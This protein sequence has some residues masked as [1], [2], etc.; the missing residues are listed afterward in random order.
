MR[1]NVSAVSDTKEVDVPASFEI[2]TK[3]NPD[4]EASWR[5][6]FYLCLAVR[7]VNSLLV[8][9]YFN[10]DEHWQ[11]LEVA[12]RLVFGYRILVDLIWPFFF[13]FF[14]SIF[15]LSVDS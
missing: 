15:I 1:Q 12:H 2:D 3:N 5:R 13:L 7:M 4:S 9:T 6:V 10:P 8:Q 14:F 11:S